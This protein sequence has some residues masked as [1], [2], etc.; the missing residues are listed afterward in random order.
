MYMP[1]DSSQSQIATETID[2]QSREVGVVYAKAFLAAA[3]KAGQ[4]DPLVEEFD[5]FVNAL[6]TLPKFEKVLSSAIVSHNDK[7]ALLDRALKGK[8]S[9]IVLNFLKVVS[10]HGRLNCLRGIQ[11][12]VREQNDAAHGRI[13]V[14][15]TTASG[16]DD[17][18]SQTITASPQPSQDDRLPLSL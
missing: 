2:A 7:A 6:R 11:A 14:K 15:L 3:K 8:A 1:T 10:S 9:A 18:L 16:I 12:A 5:S 13:P 17:G 4:T